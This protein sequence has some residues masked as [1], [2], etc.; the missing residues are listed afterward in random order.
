M[1]TRCNQPLVIINVDTFYQEKYSAPVEGKYVHAYRITIENKSEF[2]IK[3]IKRS[4]KILEGNGL[5]KTV[6]GEGVLGQQPIIKP[7]CS[8]QYISWSSLQ[9]NFGK[10]EGIYFMLNTATNEY[11]TVKIPMFLLIAPDLLN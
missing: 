3:L 6:K 7:F 2:P 1:E 4:W 10:M 9:N 11:F 8:F 5:V